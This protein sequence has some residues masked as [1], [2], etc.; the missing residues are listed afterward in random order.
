MGYVF[1]GMFSKCEYFA[2]DGKSQ[3]I[4]HG[5]N[6]FMDML[7]RTTFQGPLAWTKCLYKHFGEDQM[8]CRTHK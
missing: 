2:Q 1:L 7:D 8:S 5:P 3:T 6:M 4:R